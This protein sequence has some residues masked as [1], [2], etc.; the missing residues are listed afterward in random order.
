[1]NIGSGQAGSFRRAQMLAIFALRKGLIARA[2]RAT[3]FHLA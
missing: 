2:D 1:M 3:P